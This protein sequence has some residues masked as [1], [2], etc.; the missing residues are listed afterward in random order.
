V[1]VAAQNLIIDVYK[2]EASHEIY[3]Y[4]TWKKGRVYRV[5]G[6]YYGNESNSERHFNTEINHFL[7]FK[8]MGLDKGSH[9]IPRL[10]GYNQN[11]NFVVVTEYIQ[12]KSLGSIITDIVQK[13]RKTELYQALSEIAYFLYLLHSRSTKKINVNFNIE[14]S[15]FYDTIKRL[16]K[17]TPFSKKEE[18]YFHT[19]IRKWFDRLD[20]WEQPTVF[21]HGDCTPGNFII[22]NNPKLVV[23][24]LERCRRA[25]PA[26][27]T[28]RI[29]GELKHS[30]MRL[31]GSN[32]EA[33]PFIHYFYESYCNHFKSNRLF[34]E[35]TKRNPFYQAVTELRIAKNKWLPFDY[36][37]QLIEDAK[38]CLETG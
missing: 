22:S 29:A 20:M 26:F 35:I 16:K 10:L 3:V 25:D 4:E 33:E 34:R 31:T 6:K 24:D 2:I 36:R 38:K 23:L 37:F 5:I 27:D 14:V 17:T 1:G 13:E 18:D 19:L 15:Y 21:V 12:G 30:L 11:F 7:D 8:R 9:R 28:G 32:Y